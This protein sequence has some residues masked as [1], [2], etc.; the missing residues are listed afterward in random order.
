DRR[1]DRDRVHALKLGAL[2]RVWAPFDGDPRFDAYVEREGVELERYATFCALAEHHDAGWT[3]WP[4]EHRRPESRGVE[5]FAEA[6]ADR[7]R[8]HAWL[9]WLLDEQ[10]GAAAAEVALMGDLAIGVDPDGADAWA[11]QDVFARGVR[12]GA[13]PDA[14]NTAGQDWGLPPFVPWR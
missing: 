1:I 9:Q 6:H 4:A 3:T 11:W 2:E 8:F 5:R 13:P 7:T 10:V 12:V 14:F